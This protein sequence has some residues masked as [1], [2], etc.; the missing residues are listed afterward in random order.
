M[1]PLWL[2]LMTEPSRERSVYGTK[3]PLKLIVGFGGSILPLLDDLQKRRTRASITS[4]AEA[5][6]GRFRRLRED[7]LYGHNR[8][9]A[10]GLPG[11]SPPNPF[12]LTAI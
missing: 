4:M 11:V 8:I 5:A 7:F 2:T 6:E 9:L 10:K 12:S 3:P 1:S